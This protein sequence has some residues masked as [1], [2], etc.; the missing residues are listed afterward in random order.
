[1]ASTSET[2]PGLSPQPEQDP[3]G[4]DWARSLPRL[5]AVVVG[6]CWIGVVVQWWVSKARAEDVLHPG[7][8]PPMHLILASGIAYLACWAPYLVFS[9]RSW[10]QK[11]VR[12]IAANGAIV[13][14]VG[15]IELV[16]AFSGLDFRRLL[17]LR[18]PPWEDTRN[19]LD[20][21]LIHIRRPHYQERGKMTGGDLNLYYNTPAA[22]K[23]DYELKYDR[24]GFRN[25]EDH[26]K[27]DCVVIGD[28]FV[29]AGGVL[30]GDLFTT[31][32]AERMGATVVNLGQSHYGPQQ[33]LHVLDRFGV[34]L[35]PRACVWVFFEANDLEDTWRYTSFIEN[36]P[37][38]RQRHSSWTRRTFVGNT[39]SWLSKC[40]E[41]E[42]PPDGR[43]RLGYLPTNNGEKKMWFG[44]K[45]G[46]FTPDMKREVEGLQAT[47][48]A[49]ADAG[50]LC[51]ENGIQLVVAFAPSKFRV[52]GDLCRFEE[53]SLVRTWEV[54]GLPGILLSSIQKHSPD[55][56]VVDLTPSL[57]EVAKTGRML[58]YP[59]DTHWSPD[60]H[61]VVADTLV[62]F[63][64]SARSNPSPGG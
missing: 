10:R 25:E 32:M 8:F 35:K 45:G 34:P 59:D 4:P 41:P 42:V 60:G 58:Y 31:K 38:I 15:L 9:S 23:I 47:L 36:W 12:F 43:D 51:R 39:F 44:Y 56:E 24:N 40:L 14:A 20:D 46:P 63:L 57:K 55:I 61:Q 26:Q 37:E 11:T 29:E 5:V 2:E 33:E 54:N 53:E 64:K 3:A 1:M 19:V 17:G 16:V 22:T 6:L 7:E 27:A 18:V 48:K 50:S 21:E 62:D 49:L 13:F 30:A 28:S 52:Y